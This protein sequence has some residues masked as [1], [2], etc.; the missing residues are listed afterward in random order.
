MAGLFCPLRPVSVPSTVSI[1]DGPRSVDC[2]RLAQGRRAERDG[3]ADA[4][5]VPG[6]RDGIPAVVDGAAA[7]PKAR[8]AA[9]VPHGAPLAALLRAQA[10]HAALRR[11]RLVHQSA[12]RPEV[13]RPVAVGPIPIRRANPSAEWTKSS[14]ASS[15]SIPLALSSQRR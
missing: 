5:L 13:S 9:V 1:R 3:A 2:E 4:E 11:P 8:L 10:H 12:A 7:L 14:P 6:R 15:R